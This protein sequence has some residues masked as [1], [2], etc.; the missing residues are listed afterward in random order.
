MKTIKLDQIKVQDRL[1]QDYGDVEELAKNIRDEGLIQ[2][3]VLSGDNRLVAG[4]RR[5]SAYT[6]LSL[7]KVQNEDPTRYE[8][9]PYITIEDHLVEQG[10]LKLGEFISDSQLRRLEIEENAKR[11]SMSWQ[12]KVLGLAEYHRL[13]KREALTSGDT[14]SQAMTGS[15]LNLSQASVSIAL[16]IAK[17]LKQDPNSEL[18]QLDSLTE[19]IRY[20]VKSKLDKANTELINRFRSSSTAAGNQSLVEFNKLK[21]LTTTESK[22]EFE[23]TTKPELEPELEPEL[24]SENESKSFTVKDALFC[25]THG[26][27]IPTMKEWISNGVT[28]DHIITDPPYA[29][30]MD[31]LELVQGI[32]DVNTEHEVEPNKKLLEEFLEVSFNIVNS[33]GFLCMWYDLDQHALIQTKAKQVGWTVCRWPL[34]WCKTSNCINTTAQYNITKAVEHCMILRKDEKSLIRKKQAKNF[35][36]A[37]ADGR[38]NHPFYKPFAIWEYLIE[39]FTSPRE[40]ILDPFAGLGSSLIPAILMER[41]PHGIELNKAHYD[42]SISNLTQEVNMLLAYKSQPETQTQSPI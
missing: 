11:K 27:C 4:G 42:S 22:P 28:F 10:K 16:D 40:T 15:L 17:T 9:I 3:I 39:T 6:L 13:S 35:L 29:I 5:L 30:S 8:E 41:Y 23:S 20:K 7:N 38:R 37:E 32:D 36:L 21:A 24:N 19:A 26:D 1:R 34:H 18:W 31:N 14:W 33:G 25:M 12:E 2:P